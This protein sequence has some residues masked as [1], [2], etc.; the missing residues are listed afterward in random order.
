MHCKLS[1]QVTI[2]PQSSIPEMAGHPFPRIEEGFPHKTTHLI[3]TFTDGSI[4]YYSDLRQFGWARLGATAAIDAMVAAMGF[5]PEG[6]GDDRFSDQVLVDGLKRR[7][8]PVKTAL[9]DQ[10]LVAGLGNIYVDEALHRARIHPSTPA[11]TVDVAAIPILRE[12]I[13][14][15]L[16]EGLKQGGAKIINNK[17][18]PID[19]FPAVHARYGEACP[20]CGTTIIKVRVGQRVTYLC[21]NFQPLPP[22]VIAPPPAGKRETAPS[23]EG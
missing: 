5:G 19:A 3:I 4:F 16:G 10:R 17:A 15:A 12:A 13:T 14:W 22:D 20:D 9:L 21:P 11:N 18:Y 2:A 6:I 8:I 7:R 1:G 23:D